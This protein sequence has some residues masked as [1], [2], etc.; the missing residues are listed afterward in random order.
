MSQPIVKSIIEITPNDL[1]GATSMFEV[2]PNE[3]R[4]YGGWTKF[5][6]PKSNIAIITDRTKFMNNPL[7]SIIE[8]SIELNKSVSWAGPLPA[9]VY[10]VINAANEGVA[11]EFI[12]KY[13]SSNPKFPEMFEIEAITKHKNRLVEMHLRDLPQKSG[14]RRKMKRRQIKKMKTKRRQIKK[15]KT[16]SKKTI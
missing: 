4:N 5:E 11:I 13:A 6:L 7:Y 15:R 14:G 1:A 16:T 2:R 3:D 12:Q 10:Y 9:S 8:K